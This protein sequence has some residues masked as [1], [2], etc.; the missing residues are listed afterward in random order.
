MNK[1]LKV[2]FILLIIAMTGAMIFQN[3]R[4]PGSPGAP[5]SYLLKP[6]MILSRF[7]FIML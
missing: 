3:K 1:F 4:A 7:H 6:S 2:M 5:N